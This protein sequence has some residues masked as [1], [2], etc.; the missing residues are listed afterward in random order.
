MTRDLIVRAGA[1]LPPTVALIAIALIA[2]VSGC[3]VLPALQLA[4]LGLQVAEAVGIAGARAAAGDK[5]TN[6]DEDASR[7]EQLAGGLPFITEVR[8]DPNGAI[9]I[10]QWKVGGDPDK[11]EWEVIADATGAPEGWRHEAD[12]AQL[13]FS[14]PLETSL[15]KSK[16]HFLIFAP[17]QANDTVENEQLVSFI[18]F[19]GPAD[20]T[21]EWRGRMYNYAVAKRL[22]CFPMTS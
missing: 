15:V 6:V 8:K 7:C 5:L 4:P 12:I 13:N 1:S 14:P 21:F 3:W 11:P 10:R 22:P 19:F 17:A 16:A 2:L 9:E 20:G 18:G